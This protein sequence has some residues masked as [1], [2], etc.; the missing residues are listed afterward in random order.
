MTRRR[1][2]WIAG[3]VGVLVLAMLGAFL[4]YGWWTRR[5]DDEN[6]RGG[7]DFLDAEQLASAPPSV[8]PTA[9]PGAGPVDK[10]TATPTAQARASAAPSATSAPEPARTAKPAPVATAKPSGVRRPGTGIYKLA[11]SGKEGVKFGPLS[12]CDRT[13]PTASSLVVA[14]AQGE[15]DGSFTFDLR[16]YP[17]E[18]AQHDERQILRFTD[19]AVQL[20]FE[21]GTVTCSGIRQSSEVSYNPTVDRVRFPLKVGES[22]SGKAGNDKRLE[23]Y[24]TEIARKDVVRVAGRSYPVYVVESS[25]T[26]TGAESG[27]RRRVWWFSPELGMPLKWTDYIKGGRSGAAFS[28]D[29]TVEVT[30]L[31]E[32]P[33]R[34]E[35]APV[36]A[37][38]MAA[39]TE[40]RARSGR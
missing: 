21:V 25:A 9:P 3:G 35:E 4:G 28:N 2:A 7:A 27:E 23:S 1:G 38:R 10:P 18:P 13:L 5:G 11:V 36:A 6:S 37:P 22:W 14:P 20:L 39:V 17:G 24:T 12:F 29:V 40:A 16:Y 34:P 32:A 33:A 31:P 26:F 30:D 15:P 19:N 8:A